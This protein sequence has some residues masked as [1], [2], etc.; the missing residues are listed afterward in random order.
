MSK[1]IQ[2]LKDLTQ[3]EQTRVMWLH[4]AAFGEHS[5][6]PCSTCEGSCCK[7]CGAAQGYLR[8]EVF[9][10]AKS[11]YHFDVVSGFQ[12]P[13]GCSLPIADRS[14]T[15]LRFMC[16]EPVHVSPLESG[17]TDAKTIPSVWSKEQRACSIEIS[18]IF[19]R[20]GSDVRA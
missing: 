4:R 16:W 19:F 12:T 17:E 15:C 6:A 11:H 7:G 10:E 9:E 14:A 18:N 1:I 13:T 8:G 3:E 20:A 5:M 2:Q